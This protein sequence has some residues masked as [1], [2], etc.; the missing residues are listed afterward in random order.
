MCWGCPPT[1]RCSESM[2]PSWFTIIGC[3]VI[4]QRMHLLR[5]SSPDLPV[6]LP[7]N[8][9]QRTSDVAADE[10][11]PSDTSAVVSAGR[12]WC[13]TGVDHYSFH[14]S[15]RSLSCRISGSHL[16]SR[17]RSIHHRPAPDHRP[18]VWIWPCLGLSVRGRLF[19]W[20]PR[21]LR[22]IWTG[23]R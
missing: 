23:A 11:S 20:T 16:R 13:P 18:H 3:S 9:K 6:P 21:Y 22:L 7:R 5:G 12:A 19:W 1:R 14:V 2:E 8:A 10:L 4:V 17:L 15:P